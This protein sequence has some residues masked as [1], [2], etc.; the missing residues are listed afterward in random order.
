M[1]CTSGGTAPGDKLTDGLGENCSVE[2]QRPA[3]DVCKIE[4]NPI[5]V[6]QA[7]AA[8]YLPVAGDSRSDTE[9]VIHAVPVPDQFVRCDRAGP[10]ERTLGVPPSIPCCEVS[11]G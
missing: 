2:S 10:D 7:R 3:R 11:R 6:R 1:T 4:P 8:V 9:K 5:L